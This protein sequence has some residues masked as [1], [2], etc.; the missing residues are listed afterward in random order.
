M[1]FGGVSAAAT[2]AADGRCVPQVLDYGSLGGQYTRIVAG[3]RSGLLVGYAESATGDGKAVRWRGRNPV[4]LGATSPAIAMDV[5]DSGNIVGNQKQWPDQRA[6]MWRN[7]NLTELPTLGSATNARRINHRGVIAGSALDPSAPQMERPVFWQNGRIHVL[8]VRPGYVGGFAQGINDR[9]DVVGALYTEQL[10]EAWL[11]KA[12]GTDQ[13][14]STAGGLSQANVVDNTGRIYG[15]SLRSG[16]F[17]A[18]RWKSGHEQGLG[19][20]GTGDFSFVL[21]TNGL[22]DAVGVGNYQP[23]D[24][25][26]H[27]MVTSGKPGEPPRTLPPL[28]GNYLDPTNAH[29][30]SATFPTMVA[31]SSDPVAGHPGRATVWTCA[32]SQAFIPPTAPTSATPTS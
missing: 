12:D 29:F 3:N 5:N 23:G 24:P 14:L 26:E 27:I 31:G 16:G 19:F 2:T 17:E 4:D 7:G 8:P 6:F 18:A 10:A 22:G 32:W 9:G 15:A 25:T 28:S 20:L 13:P 1:S 30:I 11:W 21:G